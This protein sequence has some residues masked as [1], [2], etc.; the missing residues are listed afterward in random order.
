MSISNSYPVPNQI[1]HR[2]R[3]LAGNP[4]L[5]RAQAPPHRYRGPSGKYLPCRTSTPNIPS[6]G[7]R[8]YLISV[9][10]ICRSFPLLRRACSPAGTRY[11]RLPAGQPPN[12]SI[13][14]SRTNYAFPHNLKKADTVFPASAHF[15]F[16]YSPMKY[17]ARNNPPASSSK[18]P[19]PIAFPSPGSPVPDCRSRYCHG[20]T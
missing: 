12:S 17:I 20:L 18:L 6:A 19:A 16:M 15:S 11:R 2:Y 7:Q 8:C 9:S 3:C 14:W 1:P 10:D 13:S 4:I 5:C